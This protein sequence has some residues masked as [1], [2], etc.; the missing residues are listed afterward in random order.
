[1]P[2]FAEEGWSGILGLNVTIDGRD[3]GGQPKKY[4]STRNEH[5][6]R[7]NKGRERVRRSQRRDNGDN[8][9]R[10]SMPWFWMSISDSASSASVVRGPF[11]VRL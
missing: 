6:N 4:R 1:M 7:S 5:D 2:P 9:D 3:T 11:F 10:S 8:S